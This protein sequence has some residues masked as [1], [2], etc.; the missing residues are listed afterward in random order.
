MTKEI[1][2]LRQRI[3]IVEY[4]ASK[5]ATRAAR[6][7]GYSDRTARSAGSRLLAN[8]NISRE[9]QDSFARRIQVADVN[10]Q[11]VVNEIVRVAF[12]NSGTTARKFRALELMGQALGIFKN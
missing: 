5:N 10:A 7:A 11:A 6:Q 2:T 3:F 1:F 12:S 4:L 8:V 9:I